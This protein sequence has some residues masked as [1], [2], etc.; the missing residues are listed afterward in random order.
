MAAVLVAVAELIT[1]K[2]IKYNNER[3]FKKIL[4]AFLI[5]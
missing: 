3:I 1:N 4:E 2:E 5:I